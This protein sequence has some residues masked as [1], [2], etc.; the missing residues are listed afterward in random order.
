MTADARSWLNL[1]VVVLTALGLVSLMVAIRAGGAAQRRVRRA[2]MLVWAAVLATVGGGWLLHRWLGGPV[3]DVNLFGSPEL[4][5]RALTP[6]ELAALIV[7]LVVLIGLYITALLAL[8]GL[9]AGL[10][11][12]AL[13]DVGEEEPE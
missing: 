4:L 6:T 12:V 10:P 11:P 13:E 9:M 1:L 5:V 2:L 3:F 8:R 7:G